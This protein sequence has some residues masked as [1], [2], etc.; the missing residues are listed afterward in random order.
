M[1]YHNVYPLTTMLIYNF[2]KHSLILNTIIVLAFLLVA[3]SSQ[4]NQA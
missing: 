1:A 2:T 4:D 3:C